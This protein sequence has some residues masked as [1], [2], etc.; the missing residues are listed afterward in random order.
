MMSTMQ[1]TKLSSQQKKKDRYE[2]FKNFINLVKENPLTKT[3]PFVAKDL[4]YPNPH[5]DEALVLV[6]PLTHP[7]LFMYVSSYIN[8]KSQLPEQIIRIST[9]DE[10]VYG[11]VQRGS[12]KLAS[13]NTSKR[14]EAR[15]NKGARYVPFMIDFLNPE[16]NKLLYTN[17]KSTIVDKKRKY[18]TDEKTRQEYSGYV[19]M[20]HHRL[21]SEGR[22]F[23]Q[24]IQCQA[25][26]SSTSTGSP[27]KSI[28]SCSLLDEEL[29]Y[30]YSYLS[31]MVDVYKLDEAS[32]MDNLEARH[33]SHE[34]NEVLAVLANL[35]RQS[36]EETAGPSKKRKRR[37]TKTIK[38]KK[39]EVC[40]DDEV[41]ELGESDKE[42]KGGSA[43][44]EEVGTEINEEVDELDGEEDQVS[45]HD[46][47]KK[48]MLVR[49][50]KKDEMAKKSKN[51]FDYLCGNP[52]N[53]MQM[54]TRD[55]DEN[56]DEDHEDEDEDE[57]DNEEEYSQI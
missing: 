38:N 8:A 28:K 52:F 20:T 13:I 41:K 29:F 33:V 42:K 11:D 21:M 17:E 1:Q 24:I 45:D 5:S 46:I 54:S 39:D 23:V 56:D 31:C 47:P 6:L 7:E 16:K 12:V 43:D 19:E 4:A 27:A 18:D 55:D 22:S 26:K 2:V 36:E 51:T 49:K 34:R 44:K 3:K 50:E 10:V 40:Q 48:K 15:L 57:Q 14:R 32:M 9:L 30:V 25:A 35:A 37:Q 53:K